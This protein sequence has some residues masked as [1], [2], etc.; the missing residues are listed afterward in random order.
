MPPTSVKST[1]SAP[2]TKAAVKSAPKASQPS[3]VSTK[4]APAPAIRDQLTLGQVLDAGMQQIDRLRVAARTQAA[5]APTVVPKGRVT[6]SWTGASGAAKATVGVGNLA[7]GYKNYQNGD[8][9]GGGLAMVTGATETLSSAAELAA[10]GSV[11][12]AA[13]FLEKGCLSLNALGAYVSGLETIKAVNKGDM[14]TASTKALDTVAGG[15]STATSLPSVAKAIAG[16]AN[17]SLGEA[18]LAS[19]GTVALGVAAAAA[20]GWGVGRAIGS[21]TGLDEVATNAMETQFFGE[22]HKALKSL[23]RRSASD[24]RFTASVDDK[25]LHRLT[26]V[27]PQIVA[28]AVVGTLT[29]IETARTNGNSAALQEAESKL[30]RLRAAQRGELVG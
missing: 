20:T 9:L 22:G 5:K 26:K 14:T 23:E 21:N 18:A 7:S 30:Q 6:A 3:A 13:G 29:E 24:A 16:A 1:Q 12:G 27:A 28:Q 15:V 4:S 17:A 19:G 11:S 25:E 8:K 2:T 10:K